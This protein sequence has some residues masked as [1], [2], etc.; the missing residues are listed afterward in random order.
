MKRMLLFSILGFS[1]AGG[2]GLLYEGESTGGGIGQGGGGYKY[3]SI[4][5]SSGTS[6][7]GKTLNGVDGGGKLMKFSD[8]DM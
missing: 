1:G 5:T 7:A 8:Y 2:A 6:G 3:I 4:L